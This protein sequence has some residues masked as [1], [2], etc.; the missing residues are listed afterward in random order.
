M[1]A[2]ELQQ[3]LPLAVVAVSI[4]GGI[5]ADL[6]RLHARV[7]SAH[8]RIDQLTKGESHGKQETPHASA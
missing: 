8:K 6:G 4:Y 2:G 7:D 5:R 3:L 1:I